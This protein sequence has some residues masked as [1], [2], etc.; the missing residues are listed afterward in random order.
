MYLPK[1]SSVFFY[2]D[3]HHF[4][5]LWVPHLGL[6]CKW[7]NF[8]FVQKYSNAFVQKYSN[9]CVQIAQMHL[10]LCS[11]VF[12]IRICI[13]YMRES[14]SSGIENYLS[15]FLKVAQNLFVLQV[16]FYQNLHPLQLPES[17][18]SWIDCFLKGLA[19]ACIQPTILKFLKSSNNLF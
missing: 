19:A 11:N 10:F 1:Y 17:G 14:A 16:Y 2:Q 4:N 12:L 7:H 8:V 18:S 13:P 3:L 5:C 6:K 15:K 9:E